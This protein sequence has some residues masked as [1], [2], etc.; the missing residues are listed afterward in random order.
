LSERS[1]ELDELQALPPMIRVPDRN[2]SGRSFDISTPQHA[3]LCTPGCATTSIA[4]A[5]AF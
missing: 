4:V 3:A 2:L 5:L 1:S